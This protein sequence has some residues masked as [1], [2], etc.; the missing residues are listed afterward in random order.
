MISRDPEQRPTATQLRHHKVLAPNGIKTKAQLR[1]ELNAEKL[2]NEFLSNQLEEANRIIK[3]VS[4]V[5]SSNAANNNIK[6]PNFPKSLGRLIG[7]TVNR[8]NSTTIF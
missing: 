6:N 4:P 3:T 7:K 1:R 8:S 2:K 5:L